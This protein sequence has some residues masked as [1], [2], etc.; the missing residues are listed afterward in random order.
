MAPPSVAML[1]SK[2]H[3]VILEGP[4]P[5]VL[6]QREGAVSGESKPEEEEPSEEAISPVSLSEMEP[7]E[8]K[9]TPVV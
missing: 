7:E 1:P 2:R 9:A 8:K 4:P 3:P 6:S 5:P